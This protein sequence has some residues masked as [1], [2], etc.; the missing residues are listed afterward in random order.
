MRH[1][2]L[3]VRVRRPSAD[4]APGPCGRTEER[5][6]HRGMGPLSRAD[7]RASTA[8]VWAPGRRALPLLQPRRRLHG[9]ARYRHGRSGGRL[10]RNLAAGEWV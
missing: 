8:G 1:R 3:W 6:H 10:R 5:N 9:G 2:K 7:A 4:P